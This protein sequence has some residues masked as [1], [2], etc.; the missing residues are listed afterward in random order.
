[1]VKS[2]QIARLDGKTL[3][4]LSAE[5]EAQQWLTNC[6]AFQALCLRPPSTMSRYENSLSGA[7]TLTKRI[8]LI[9]D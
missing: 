4:V 8:W 9:Y 5:L 6:L 7:H 3:Y 1:M 2:T